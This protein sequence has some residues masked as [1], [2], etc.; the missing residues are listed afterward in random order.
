MRADWSAL[1]RR[2]RARP[3]LPA[4]ALLVL[5]AGVGS[6][7]A[8]LG[9]TYAAL[10][11]G[12]PYPDAD[13]L[14]A[15]QS[16][17]PGMTLAGMGLSGPEASELPTLTRSFS[18]V[19]VGYLAGGLIAGAGMPVRADIA[20]VS[21]GWIGALGVPAAD[22]R[23]FTPAEDRP[24]GPCLAVLSPRFRAAAFD[25][26]REPVGTTLRIDGRPCEVVGVWPDR[27]DFAGRPADV[28]VPLQYD[29]RSPSAN[30]ANHAFTVLARLAPGV[31]PGAARADLARAVDGWTAAT[32]QFHSPSTAFHPLSMI[33]LDTSIRGPVRS[34]GQVLVAA[35]VV[36]LVVT[37]ANAGALL[38]ADADRRRQELALRAV[39]GADRRRIWRLHL[40]EAGALAGIA[41]IAGAALAYGGSRLIAALAPPALASFD[42]ALPVWQTAL[43]AAVLAAA[44]AAIGS[45]LQVSRL[46]WSSLAPALGDDGRTSTA[47]SRRQRLRRS[48]VGVEVALAVA[49]IACAAVMV[50][51]VGRLSR[52]ALGFAAD[53][54]LHA[55]INL[56]A[57]RYDT[58]ARIDA[59]YDT[60]A[61]GLRARP[62]VAAVGAMSGLVPDRRPN[63]SSF[64][65]DGTVADHTGTPPVQFVQY[66][67][68]E[69]FTTLGMT[70]R[71][72]RLFTSTDTATSQPVAI[73]NERAA[74][75]YFSGRDPVGGR[76]RPMGAGFAW[77]TVVGVVADARQNGLAREPGTEVF[78]PLAQADGALGRAAFTR[79]LHVMVRVRS[80][81]PT[82]LA[83]ALREAVRQT[84]PGAAVSDLEPLSAVVQRAVAT[85]RFLAGMIGAFAGVALLLAAVGL[86]GLVAHTVGDR[87]REIGI[88]RALGAPQASL[89][90]LIVR[91]LLPMVGL[92]LA[93][94]IALG[95]GGARLLTPFSF[96]T[97]LA[98]PARLA[99]VAVALLIVA[100][101]ACARPLAAALRVDPAIALRQP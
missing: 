5:V 36:M 64:L 10:L 74:R 66:L 13:D 53:G 99:L 4:L 62:D 90:R 46:P 37:I 67:T 96:E 60:L 27:L 71:R 79:D 101:L 31:S 34:T 93:A 26:R 23:A 73:V 78:V 48:L 41:A 28:W 84:D 12:L 61:A 20:H 87:A 22:G 17:F 16:A 38:V 88:R 80:G 30:R 86:Y 25:R 58:R 63:N 11:R 56:P 57:D 76:L 85:E 55:R 100:A 75:T 6:G 45:L 69:A 33:P 18:H 24:S 43:L 82:S 68:P 91:R 95:A 51:S 97:E 2:W 8:V 21:A 44:A 77:L 47:T 94:G 14:F 65:V 98:S 83:P 32:G 50:E 35:V 3:A 15:V 49:L 39:L 72:G 52:V 7:A 89:I 92:G 59:F 40:V 1:R 54:V 19:G 9:A 29:V 70:L 42:L 81:D